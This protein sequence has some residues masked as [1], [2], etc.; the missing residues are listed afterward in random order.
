MTTPKALE[1][2]R[3]VSS[4][5]GYY[6]V[7]NLGRVR[8]VDRVI[9]R[10]NWRKQSFKGRVL[11][12]AMVKGYLR[13]GL[14]KNGVCKDNLIH[15]LVGVEFIPNS[16]SKP[17]INHKDGVKDNNVVSN[18]EWTT[19]RENSDHATENGFMAS[20]ERVFNSKLTEKDVSDIRDKYDGGSQSMRNLAVEYGVSGNT[21]HAAI[22]RVTWRHI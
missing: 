3:D 10:K 14:C 22:N 11:K 17:Y 12:S 13:V 2:F 7:S 15:R 1:E 18:L 5:E 9:E 21:I 8:S 6:Q 4:Y 20:G 16:E 19:P